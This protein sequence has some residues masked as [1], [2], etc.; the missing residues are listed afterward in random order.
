VLAADGSGSMD[1]VEFGLQ[2]AGYA[3]AIPHP[4]V[5]G[6]FDAFVEIVEIAETRAQLASVAAGPLGRPQ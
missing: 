1:A 4:D 5:L 6:G 3:E 2:R